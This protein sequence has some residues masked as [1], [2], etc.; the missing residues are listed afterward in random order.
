MDTDKDITLF[1]KNVL[2]YL[3]ITLIVIIIF[4][5]MSYIYIRYKK[6]YI[7]QNWATERC[8]P[9]I[10]PFAHY[11]KN[12]EEGAL[13]G[14]IKHFQFCS[15]KLFRPLFDV[16]LMPIRS[17]MY[18]F[19]NS[20]MNFSQSSNNMRKLFTKIRII[21][22][23]AF[24][25]IFDRI[26]A[27]LLQ[28]RTVFVRNTA[29]LRKLIGASKV[30]TYLLSTIAFT[31]ISMFR[32]I[33]TIIKRFIQILIGLGWLTLFFC[34]GPILA[35]LS[36]WAAGV[37]LKWVC[38]DENTRII[39]S[40]GMKQKISL[41][42]IGDYV[43]FGGRVTGVFRFNAKDVTMY[44]YKNII[45]SSNHSVYDNKVWKHIEDC[46]D[47]YK[48]KYT[49]DTIYCLATENNRLFINDILFTD[50]YE[51]S[52]KNLI[53]TMRNKQIK[54]LNNSTSRNYI[55]K[56]VDTDN[57][58]FSSQAKIKMA[59]GTTK[60]IYKISIGDL[61]EFGEILGVITLDCLPKTILYQNRYKPDII[62]TGTQLIKQERTHI[63]KCV[64]ERTD[65]FIIY[66]R[67]KNKHNV[68][69]IYQLLTSSGIVKIDQ[70]I[71][72]DYNELCSSMP[73]ETNAID[74]QLLDYL[75]NTV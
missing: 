27:I 33:G 7:I 63:W 29:L 37:G 56:K 42:R 64:Y 62:V 73:N 8:K 51:V 6:K 74:Q 26:S 10:I 48:I 53:N 18:L 14:T 47:A 1:S 24:N 71:F 23:V 40:N 30:V 28:A 2:H 55:N 15:G 54:T 69:Y 20:L 57:F 65:D 50:Y 12:F 58:G 31:A 75:N 13:E 4:F 32:T 25:E 9:Y 39:M 43:M 67:E 19:Q 17:T 46:D 60:Q 44:R 59:N 38:F 11:I 45:V 72:T 61:T 21:C 34:C 52:N 68:E 16:M 5:I 22:I 70:Y 3:I 49:K 35:V 41:T 36:T 66:D